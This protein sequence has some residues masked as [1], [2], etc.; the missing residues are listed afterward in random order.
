MNYHPWGFLIGC[1]G[2]RLLITYLASFPSLLRYVGYFA[3]FPVAGWLVIML[4]TGRDSGPEA[5]GGKIWWQRWRPLHAALWAAFA[6]LALSEHPRAWLL[7]LLDTAIGLLAFIH[8]Y[9]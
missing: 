5:T 1:I 8:R 7:L 3:L 4:V 9:S 2:A 6:Y